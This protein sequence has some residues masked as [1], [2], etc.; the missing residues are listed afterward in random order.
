MSDITKCRATNCPVKK[1]C[2]RFTAEHDELAQ[3]YFVY[4]PG[5]Y[6]TN[7]KFVCDYYWGENGHK[8]WSEDKIKENNQ[9]L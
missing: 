6:K 4:Q 1:E 8:I 5:V 2:Y 3:A 7:G 9:E